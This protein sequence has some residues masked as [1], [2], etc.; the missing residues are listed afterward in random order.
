MAIS[1]C[2]LLGLLLASGGQATSYAPEAAPAELK[3]AVEKAD[4]A[5]A[6]LRVALL[7][8]LTAELSSGGP[9]TAMSACHDAAPE[10]AKRVRAEQGISLG[11]T[12]H[13]LRN[14]ENRSPEWAAAHVA[15]AGDRPASDAKARV[16]DLGD[17]VGVLR[18]IPAMA[19]CTNCHGPADQ[20]SSDL[21]EA[22]AAL[23]PTDKATGFREGDLRGWMWAEVPKIP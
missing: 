12:S 10:I 17:R 2:A 3:P 21:R 13:R 5:F 1:I 22:L 15:A 14:P 11:R 7:T 20:I 18:P 16:F 4:E 8:R 23:Y 9:L 19:M 6:Q